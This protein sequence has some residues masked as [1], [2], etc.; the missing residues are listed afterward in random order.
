MGGNGSPKLF[1]SQSSEDISDL[2]TLDNKINSCNIELRPKGIIV[3]FRSILE[4]FALVIPYHKLTI[5]KSGEF[6]IY[7]DAQ[8]IKVNSGEKTVQKFFRKVLDAKV[9][10]LPLSFQDM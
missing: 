9:L 1:V 4:T 10:A 6:S 3:R 5:F 2:L 7:R 8:Y